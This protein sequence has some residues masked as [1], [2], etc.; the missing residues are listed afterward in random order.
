MGVMTR[1]MDKIMMSASFLV[2]FSEEDGFVVVEL[3]GEEE[4][5]LLLLFL[6]VLS[7]SLSLSLSSRGMSLPIKGFPSVLT[8]TILELKGGTR[9]ERLLRTS[10][11]VW[12]LVRLARPKG[13]GPER[14][15]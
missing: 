13:M 10:S 7:L 3:V 8:S 1:R 5:L 12:S 11:T 14:S 9:P 15:L 2:E 4:A 6:L